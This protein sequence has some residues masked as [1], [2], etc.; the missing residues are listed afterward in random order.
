[1]DGYQGLLGEGKTMKVTNLLAGGAIFFTL[2]F[3]SASAGTIM[4]LAT[5]LNGTGTLQSTGGS[6]DANWSYSDPAATPTTGQAEVVASNDADWYSGWL[7]NGPNSDWIAPN[8]NVTNNG[9]APYSFSETFNLS[10][11]TLSTV[12]ITGGAW[13]I[14]DAGTLVL[15][16]HTLST[17][18]SGAWGSLTSFTAPNADFVQGVNTLTI[19]ITSDDQFLEAVRLE[20]TLTGTLGSSV[21]E[22]AST[23]TLAVGL[24]AIALMAGV[25]RR[26]RS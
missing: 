5:G 8:P 14:D 23:L 13:A 16:G 10:A 18:G 1:M 11:Y 26:R 12:T 4:N 2:A 19:T 9:P 7:A 20:G 25:R 6:T 21:P 3:S 15:N 22:P 24:G 17:L